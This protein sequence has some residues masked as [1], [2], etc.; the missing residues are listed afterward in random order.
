MDLDQLLSLEEQFY[1]EGYEEGAR[2]VEQESRRSGMQLGIQTGYQRLLLLGLLIG[3]LKGLEGENLKGSLSLEDFDMEEIGQN[4]QES[5]DKVEK[6]IKKARNWLMINGMSK[7]SAVPKLK[8]VDE[9]LSQIGG[10]ISHD[11]TEW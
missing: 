11:N 3:L 9:L 1:R 7:N 5:I 4:N 10:E 8:Y 6:L 2:D